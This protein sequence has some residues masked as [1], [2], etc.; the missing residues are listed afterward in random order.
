M[1]KI[2]R[3]KCSSRLADNDTGLYSSKEISYN[4]EFESISEMYDSFIKRAV[5]PTL[6]QYQEQLK[7][8]FTD[9]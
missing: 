4:T 8:F 7:K 9:V 3:T 1:E 5:K 2:N 6:L